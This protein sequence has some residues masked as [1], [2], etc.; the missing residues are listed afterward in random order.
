VIDGAVFDAWNLHAVILLCGCETVTLTVAR[1][2]KDLQKFRLGFL[3]SFKFGQIAVSILRI[4]RCC[5]ILNNDFQRVPLVFIQ[6]VIDGT[7][8]RSPYAFAFTFAARRTR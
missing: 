5:T 6:Q 4:T 1:V 8:A 3:S 7:S 2:R